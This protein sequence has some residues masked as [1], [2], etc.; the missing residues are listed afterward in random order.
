MH[1]KDGL[2]IEEFADA[3]H[4][5][6]WLSAHA[7]TSAGL[8]LKIGKRGAGVATVTYA[9]ALEY[10]LCYGWIDGQKAALDGS[11]WLQRFTPRKPNSRWSRVNRESAT[12]LIREGRMRA[13][14]AEAVEAAKAN[15]NW[16]RAYESPSNA[17]VPDDFRQALDASPAA[18]DFFETL[19]SAN[20]Y[21]ILYRIQHVKRAET[22]AR[23]IDQFIRM[24]AEHR[25]IHD[26][27]RGSS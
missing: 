3:E 18:G 1:G 15:G 10:A 12:K 21:A 27:G 26:A 17:T 23:K 4:F 11:F 2:P 25:K 13:S 7:G 16:D 9:E 20:R 14:G 5:E 22:R 24:L 19:D 8:W 6:Q